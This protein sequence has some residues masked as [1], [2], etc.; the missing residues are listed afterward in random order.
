MTRKA[1]HL[2]LDCDNTLVLS[3]ELAFAGC[4]GLVNRV[5]AQHNVAFQFAPDELMTRFVGMNFRGIILALQNEHGFLLSRKEVDALVDEE[6]N[7]IT[8]QL[9]AKVQLCANVFAALANLDKTK[10]TLAVVSSSDLRRVKACLAATALDRMIRP[11]HAPSTSDSRS[12][13]QS[14]VRAGIRVLG[15][16]G[17]YEVKE[18]DRMAAVLRDAGAVDVMRDWLA[19]QQLI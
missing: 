11:D 14:A 7:I 18:Q 8:E 10:Y 2:L 1:T 19:F 6:V 4:C 5:L 15:Y 3:E 12:G 17:S 16:V 9:S 13:L